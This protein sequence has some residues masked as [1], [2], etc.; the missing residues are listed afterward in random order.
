V[1]YAVAFVLQTQGRRR[2]NVARSGNYTQRFMDK[3]DARIRSCCRATASLSA[4]ECSVASAF[5]CPVLARI[6]KLQ[7]TLQRATVAL[8]AR[9]SQRRTTCS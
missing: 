7:R 8:L 4:A 1:R 2:N 6:Q 5:P 3:L 9:I